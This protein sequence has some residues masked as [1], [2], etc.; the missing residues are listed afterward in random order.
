MDDTFHSLAWNADLGWWSGNTGVP[1]PGHRIDF[2]TFQAD[3]S[4]RWTRRTPPVDWSATSGARLR[5]AEPSV[6][7]GSRKSNG[8]CP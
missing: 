8:K 4:Y 7:A 2:C 1:A 6:R 3:Q 5:A